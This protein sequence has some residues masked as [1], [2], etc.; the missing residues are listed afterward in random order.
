MAWTSSTVLAS[1]DWLAVKP[2]NVIDDNSRLAA[3]IGNLRISLTPFWLDLL[4]L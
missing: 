1:T 4:S 2:T 3:V